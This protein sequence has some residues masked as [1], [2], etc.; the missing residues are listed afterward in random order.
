VRPRLIVNGDDFG[1]T[2]SLTRGVIA[3]YEHG[4]LTSTSIVAGSV[5][6]D[7]AVALAK[8]HPGLGVGVHLVVDEYAPVANPDD[9]PSLLRARGGFHSRPVALLEIL[10]GRVRREE[11]AREWEA[12]I[13]RVVDAG[14][15][16]THLDGHG[17]CHASPTLAGV[18]ADLAAKFGIGA[19]RLPAE[20]LSWRGAGGALALRRH[21]E[22]GLL[23]GACRWPRSRW[24]GRLRHPDVFFG[25][26]DAGRLSAASLE[27]I[28]R[29]LRPGVSELMTHPALDNGDSPYGLRYDWRGDLD[30]LLAH[31]KAEF[32]GRFGV[33]LV[34]F[35]DAWGRA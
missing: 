9:V 1:R 34:S 6:F 18:V 12:Q 23:S 24:R 31:D 8:E 7:L 3:A 30:A 20:R 10:L 22:R 32:T 14:L 21:A 33:D 19:V 35:R 15:Q 25:F 27:A 11:V 28:A 5:H 2:E 16:P 17:H 29:S 13:A 26:M 4:I